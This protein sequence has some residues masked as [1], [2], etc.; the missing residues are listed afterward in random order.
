MSIQIKK[1]FIKSQAVDGGKVLFLNEDSFKALKSNGDVAELF[2]FSN[3]D[4]LVM[5]QMPQVSSDPVADE[6]LARKKYV[7]D[8]LQVEVEAREAADELLQ[9]NISDEVTRATGEEA[10]IEGK[11]DAEITNRIAAVVAETAAREA[12]DAQLASDLAAEEAARIAGDAEL[13][14]D[15]A[16]EEAARIAAVSAEQAAREAADTAEQTARI[17]GD[18][19]VQAAVDAEVLAR[20]AAVSAEQAAREAAD[21]QL[22]SDIATEQAARIADVDAEETRALAAEAVLQSAIDVEKGRVDAILLASDADKDSFA[23]IVQLINSVDTE[24]DSAFASYVLSNNAALAQEVSDRQAGDTALQSEIDAEETRALAAEAA[25]DARLDV[26]ETDPTTKTYVDQQ[27]ASVSSDLDDLD[28]YAQEIR[29]DLDDLD[30][31]AQEIRSDL[32]QEILDRVADVN[33]EETRALAAEAELASDLA[34]EESARI[35]GD[36]ALQSGL[37]TEIANRQAAVSA[38]EAARIA[39]DTE[40]ASDLAA[41]EAARIAG[42]SALQTSLNT[43]VANRIAAVSAEQAAREAADDVLDAKIDQKHSEALSYTDSKVAA[44]VN[45][46]PE[47]LDTLKELADALGGDENFATTIAGQIGAEQAAREAADAALDARLDALEGSGAGSLAYELNAF[48]ERMV[49]ESFEVDASM[50]SD[51]YLDLDHKAFVPSM[52]VSLDRLMLF[53]GEDFSV[54]VVGGVSRLTF[55]GSILPVGDEALAAGDKI[56]VRYLKD[57]R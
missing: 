35:A 40:L 55:M 23:E 26:L 56:K 44:L 34:A 10:R 57:V 21:A 1:K 16:A 14:S 3:G 50:I 8:S 5:L 45:S 28:S 51:G 41:E 38:E 53:E 32:D 48:G 15:L 22:A 43:E 25:L 46:A 47:V 31:Y 49:S 42:D 30:G 6:D 27:I 29:S 52:V 11:L 39:G 19:A 37:N 7:D 9:E 18:A 13:A 24:N 33:A 4:K 12:A 36:A 17:A 54:S 2:K 20:E